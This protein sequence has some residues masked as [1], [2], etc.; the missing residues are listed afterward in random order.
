[1]SDQEQVMIELI[2]RARA[3]PSAEATRF[4]I[5][6]NQ[7]LAAGTITSTPKQPLAP[8]QLLVNAAVG[9][10]VD[11]INRDFFAHN[12]PDG[13]TPGNRA[14]AAGYI[15]N[16]IA[17]NISWGGYFGTPNATTQVLQSHELLF[18][19]AGHRVNI[20]FDSVEEIG[21]GIRDGAFTPS[22]GNA[23]LV[24]QN[25]GQRNLA[26]IITGVVY[27]D[28]NDSNFYD[29]GEAVRAGTVTATR[30][31]DN[32]VYSETIGTSGGYGIVVPAGVYTV[33]ARYTQSGQQR[34]MSTTVTVQSA[35]LKVD[36]DTQDAVTGTLSLS[37]P[38]TSINESGSSN[39]A[40]FTVTRT[41]STTQPVTV[42]LKSSKTADAKVPASVTIPAG[43][44]TATFV[45]TGVADG[46]ID[47]TK[48]TTITATA[49]NYGS[50]TKTLKVTDVTAPTLPTT[51]TVTTTRPVFTWTPVSNAVS[52]RLYMNNRTTGEKGV[53]D[54]S[55]ITGTTF[56]SPVDLPLG[57]YAFWVRGT[58]AS[59][60]IG[61]WSPTA[62]WKVRPATVVLNPGRTEKTGSFK[63]QWNPVLGADKYELWITNQTTNT[64]P[65]Y[66]NQNIVGTSF[67]VSNLEIGRYAVYA[68]G[69]TNSGLVSTT[70]PQAIVYV[71]IAVTGLNVT[72]TTLTSSPKV[73]WNPIAGAANYDVW[74][75][76]L[77]TSVS[78]Y[79]RNAS[80]SGTSISLTTL[81][82]GKYKVSVRARDVRGVNYSVGSTYFDFN[83][84]PRL[85]TQVTFPSA[86]KPM[87]TWTQVS[88][89]VKYELVIAN[90][91]STPLA[92]MS[93]IT[94][95]GY[96][97]GTAL[98]SGSYR[99]WIRAFDSSGKVTSKSSVIS[100]TVALNDGQDSPAVRGKLI[101]S[102]FESADH[103]LLAEHDFTP[104]PKSEPDPLFSVDD[105]TTHETVEEI[106]PSEPTA[107]ADFD[108]KDLVQ[109][110][111]TGFDLLPVYS[112]DVPKSL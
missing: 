112:E 80:V 14:T 86:Q 38:V 66:R 19:S 76:N 97:H 50:T 36:F 62:N 4:G 21:V 22:G 87:F 71:D 109:F 25:F 101:D 3:N 108:A 1:M 43:S 84:T 27:T 44:K 56:T 103:W 11:M 54:Q 106:P 12:N 105:V 40:T 47:G 42:T 59:G 17:E 79:Y 9:H 92:T 88:G 28:S 7:N 18:K 52:Y 58:T 35:N 61:A 49:V 68:R 102:V 74:V 64:S 23:T 89:A 15:W 63:V 67:N 39:T 78:P 60:L 100:F 45:V 10:S 96:T 29:I 81:T 83:R 31:S 94:G 95:L 51:K 6:L 107:D 33:T 53:I 69:L 48:T 24:T 2:N 30:Q 98:A 72:A 75:T 82:P 8:N 5:S 13:K 90:S 70:S 85:S 20:L 110:V 41:G 99:A 32:A 73:E 57:D 16:R 91:S 111:T 37:S 46:L 93:N 65:Y 77:T 55:G 104:M 26:A 34:E